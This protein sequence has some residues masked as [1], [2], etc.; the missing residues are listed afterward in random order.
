[1]HLRNRLDGVLGSVPALQK[2][3]VCHPCQRPCNATGAAFNPRI[4]LVRGVKIVARI[5][6]GDFEGW[7]WFAGCRIGWSESWAVCLTL[8]TTWASATL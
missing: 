4:E 2:Q 6:I 3:I 1:M 5:W 8:P 7:D